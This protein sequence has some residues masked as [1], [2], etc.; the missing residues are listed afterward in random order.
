MSENILIEKDTYLSEFKKKL[1]NTPII[2]IQTNS[3][4]ANIYAKCEWENPTGSIKDRAAY[5][6]IMNLLSQ[7][8]KEKWG[9]IHV[10]EYSGGNLSLS[11]AEICYHLDIKVTLVLSSGA[12]KSLVNKLKKLNVDIHL[13]D[14][15]KG[16]WGVMEYAINLAHSNPK[17][18]FL[19][20]H[21]N[22]QNLL[23][24]KKETG[25]EILEWSKNL[26]LELNAWIASVGTGGTLIGVYETLKTKYPNIELHMVM[27]KELTY[28]S[29]QPP[30]GL[31]KYA[32]SGGLG[33]SRKQKFV[34]DNEECIASE[35]NYSFEET[36]YEM[37]DF[38][39]KTGIKIGTSAAANLLAAK[40]VS[41]RLDSNQNI[42]TI[43]P[44]S[45]SEEE[46][47]AVNNL[48]SS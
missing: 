48:T 37:R 8:P 27:P 47:E 23:A 32:G 10:L 5:S 42:I 43:F 7:T 20:Q 36:L 24:H 29:P 30:N 6:M 44:D 1:G 45:G 39:S 31:R 28:G 26:N 22:Q 9:D 19:Y 46:W 15:Q 33:N 14:K 25:K 18:S 21:T 41:E 40:K 17:W 35:L 16:F 38:F 11:I 13:V 2:E 34:E 3:N 4:C 12:G